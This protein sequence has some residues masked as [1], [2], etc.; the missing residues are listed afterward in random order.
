V[1]ALAAFGAPLQD[2]TVEDLTV[3][4]TFFIMGRAPNQIDI[5]TTIDDVCFERAWKNRVTSTYGGVSV[6]YIGRDD[7]IANKTAADRLQDR[8]DV[9]YLREH[10]DE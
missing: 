3:P 6:N 10:E 1:H 5:I 2:L 4:Q 8:A 9:A 7:L